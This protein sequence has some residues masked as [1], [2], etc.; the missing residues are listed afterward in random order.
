MRNIN[1]NDLMDKYTIYAMKKF[2]LNIVS[3]QVTTCKCRKSVVMFWIVR[4]ANGIKVCWAE[5]P[6]GE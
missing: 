4:R 1:W 3:K 6:L 2:P 5:R